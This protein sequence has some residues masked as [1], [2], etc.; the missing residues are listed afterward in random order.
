LD[1]GAALKAFAAIFP[2][3]LPDK[4]K[5]ATILLVARFQ[6][7]G[8]VWGGTAAAYLV[9]VVIAVG[10]GSLL[11]TLPDL[12]VTLATAGLFLVGAVLLWRS[13][14]AHAAEA[15]SELDAAAGAGWA[16]PPALRA[17]LASFGVIFVAEWGDMSQLV[18]AGLAGSTGA[19]AA[20]LTVSALAVTAGQGLVK[21]LPL[22]RLQRFAAAVFASLA[23]LT[24]TGVG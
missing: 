15:R 4:T 12:V 13:A 14:A 5:V 9:H 17:A 2:A 16:R 23:L 19:L 20:L 22:D 3:E 7:P 21:R 11:G 8:A 24:L 18:M 1:I 10:A 6:H